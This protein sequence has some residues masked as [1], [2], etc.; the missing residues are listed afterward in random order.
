MP[1]NPLA[2]P[3]SA[4]VIQALTNEAS[5]Y[6][7]ALDE[8]WFSPDKT[9]VDL[10]AFYRRLKWDDSGLSIGTSSY[11]H[12][13]TELRR[14]IAGIISVSVGSVR[15]VRDSELEKPL[16]VVIDNPPHGNITEVPYKVKSGPR[17]KLANRIASLLARNAATVHEIFDPP[18]N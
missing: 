13:E 1:D 7:A 8:T 12:R 18:H 10:A 17:R 6:R 9:E 2:N 14:P 11:A 3:P 15:D 16:D 4:E 5:V